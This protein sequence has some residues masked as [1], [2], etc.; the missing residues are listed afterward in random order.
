[1]V[2]KEEKIKLLD[3]LIDKTEQLAFKDSNSLD[4]ILT[5]GAMIIRNIII[6]SYEY[7]RSLESVN[8]YSYFHPAD[9][10]SEQ[11]QWERGKERLKTLLNSI[12]KEIQLFGDKELI[13]STD[14]EPI[15]ERTNNIFIVHGHDES[16]K[17]EV[18][19]TIEALGLHPIILHEQPN[20]GLT[21]IE[22]FEKHS[23]NCH[24]AIVLLSPDDEGHPKSEEE[25]KKFR[26]RQN[27][28]LE[29]GYF[30]GML[31]RQHVL[32]LVKHDPTGDLDIPNDFAGVVYTEFDKGGGWKLSIA[33]QL[34]QNGYNI[35]ANDLFKLKI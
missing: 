11:R 21:I 13:E 29:L 3:D 26:A 33:Q 31:G 30:V 12:K 20:D 27:V 23:L 7:V 6:D 17:S 28:I 32:S 25:A 14:D 10:A 35:N 22:K 9:P 18:A 5:E 4:E 16:M 2:S 1:M 15:T 34:M 19:R 24:F 8:F